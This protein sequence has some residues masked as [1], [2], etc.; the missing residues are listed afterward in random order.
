MSV[1]SIFRIELIYY[2][3]YYNLLQVKV[4]VAYNSKYSTNKVKIINFMYEIK[5]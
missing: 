1:Y 3:S 2:T 4:M 5:Y